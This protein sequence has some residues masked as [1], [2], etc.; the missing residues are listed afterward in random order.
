M[1]KK[2]QDKIRVRL[3][4]R[5]NSRGLQILENKLESEMCETSRKEELMWIQRSRAKWLID[6]EQ[7]TKY[8]HLKVVHRRRLNKI[9]MMRNGYMIWIEDQEQVCALLKSY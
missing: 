6:D 2:C 1:S 4:V 8:Y 3:H 9:T 5:N 7:N